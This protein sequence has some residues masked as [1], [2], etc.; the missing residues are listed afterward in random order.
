M[1]VAPAK[2]LLLQDRRTIVNEDNT[3]LT[4]AYDD[5]V[6]EIF[7][8][9]AVYPDSE[10]ILAR[11]FDHDFVHLT[12][13]YR[14]SPQ[15]GVIWENRGNWTIESGLRMR[16]LDATSARRRDLQGTVLKSCLVVRSNFVNIQKSEDSSRF[17][18]HSFFN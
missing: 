2:W 1:F 5:S 15:R 12:S 14:P 18:W 17:C 11:R 4:F 13:V 8:N 10:V 6:L 3:N 9:L 16:N 7:E